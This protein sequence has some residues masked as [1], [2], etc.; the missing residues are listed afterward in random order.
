V[1][2]LVRSACLIALTT[3]GGTTKPASPTLERLSATTR[4]LK[5]VVV[6][7]PSICGVPDLSDTP[8]DAMLYGA[9]CDE[10]SG[11][12]LDGA[13]VIATS[14]TMTQTA[15]AIANSRGAFWFEVPPGDYSLTV[16][17]GSCTAEANAHV[18]AGHIPPL[19]Q[20]IRADCSE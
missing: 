3:C 20:S 15:T 2:R 16:Y 18:E 1:T 9:V 6:E 12:W 5:I 11:E 19:T 8:P 10:R 14:D 7:K 17:Y 4:R 13:T